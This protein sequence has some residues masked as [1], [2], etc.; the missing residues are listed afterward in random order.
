MEQKGRARSFFFRFL[1]DYPEGSYE[2]DNA[3]ILTRDSNLKK[4][5]SFPYSREAILYIIDLTCR[6]RRESVR[7]TVNICEWFL[8]MRA[9]MISPK[10]PFSSFCSH[11]QQNV[12]LFLWILGGGK[13]PRDI[14]RIIVQ[15][16]IQSS[17]PCLKCAELMIE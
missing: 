8:R 9:L 2:R 4:L 5:V 3:H 12:M 16:I 6:H 11:V 1:Y 15:D 7:M 10:R 17:V 14:Q 13:L